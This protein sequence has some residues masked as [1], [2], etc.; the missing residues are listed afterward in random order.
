[1]CSPLS[2]DAADNK[3]KLRIGQ[4]N[5]AAHAEASPSRMTM[6]LSAKH[7]VFGQTFYHHQNGA[8]LAT[9]RGNKRQAEAIP[10]LKRRLVCVKSA[11][12]TL[13]DPSL[14]S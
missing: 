14:A 9:C 3:F 1:M 2:S 11:L 13:L 6:P 7:L 4:I 10:D 8:D 12:K 5:G